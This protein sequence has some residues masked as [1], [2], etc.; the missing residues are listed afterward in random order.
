M[1][2]D[3]AAGPA[4]RRSGWYARPEAP[5][6]Q[7]RHPPRLASWDR[8]GQPAQVRLATYLDD[9]EEILAAALNATADDP[10]PLALRLDVGL[11]ASV[12]LLAEHDL[13]NYLLPVARHLAPR[14]GPQLVTVWGTKRHAPGSWIRLEAARPTVP[15]ETPIAP[16][17]Q[18]AGECLVEVYTT[19][20]AESAAY[21]Q[22]IHDQ[23]RVR[24]LLP[25][26]P[27]HLEVSFTVGPHR[28]WLNLWKP[29]IDA[30]DAVLGRTR[31]DRS[32]HPRDGRITELGLHRHH[33]PTLGHDV[34]IRLWAA[35]SD[36]S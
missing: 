21:K 5:P 9:V 29:T 25:E 30:L 19:A 26:G 8:A 22:Q 33:D 3:P 23:V 27:V 35:P 34:A 4:P 32:W 1:T 12:P 13:D 24:D 16:A 15:P 7:L 28:N 11:A 36:P 6:L 31:P 10:S 17:A 20:S 2:V 18:P 14:I